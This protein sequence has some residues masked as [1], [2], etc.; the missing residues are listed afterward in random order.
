MTSTQQ[1][2]HLL[3]SWGR[4]DGVVGVVARI[5]GERV[6]LFDPGQ[7]REHT[8]AAADVERVPAAAVR[9]TLTADL[10]LPHGLDE[11]DVRRWVAMLT[12]PVL[13]SRA[14]EV[15]T[16]AGLDIGVTLPTVEMTVHA[17]EDGRAR[18]LCGGSA[19]AD[20]LSGLAPP[21]TCPDCGRRLAPPVA[22]GT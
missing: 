3:G 20:P 9:V 22:P 18:C 8:V 14:A 21:R 16:E 17:H 13:R 11:A 4:A 19:P 1:P 7:R 15:L 5:A 12:D 10:P 2:D 6:T